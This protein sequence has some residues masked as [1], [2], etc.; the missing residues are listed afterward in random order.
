[1]NII[2]SQTAS[3]EEVQKHFRLKIAGHSL[4]FK[5]SLFVRS[6]RVAPL[7]TVGGDRKRALDMGCWGMPL[8]GGETVV[9]LSGN[10][11]P[12]WHAMM[13]PPRRCI[14][15]ATSFAAGNDPTWFCFEEELPFSLFSI[16]GVL[17]RKAGCLR[18]LMVTV[19]ANKAVRP[20]A[21]EMPMVVQPDE[22]ACWLHA[23]WDFASEFIRPYEGMDLQVVNGNR[24]ARAG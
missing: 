6:N 22:I 3:L 24:M 4:A 8:S 7:V 17:F 2:Y 20:F 1:M 11:I 10:D 5:R 13:E 15:P 21:R 18:F 9:S 16:A 23:P 12:R 19:P 14:I